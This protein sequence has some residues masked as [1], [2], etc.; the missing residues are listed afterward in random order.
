MVLPVNQILTDFTASGFIVCY[1]VVW[2]NIL[3]VTQFATA[4]TG[5]T[6]LYCT[7]LY[8]SLTIEVQHGFFH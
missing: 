2:S 3:S 7:I 6:I 4:V 1:K 5:R 8:T